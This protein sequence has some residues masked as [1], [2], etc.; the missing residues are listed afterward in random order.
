[1]NR[2][3]EFR[4]ARFRRVLITPPGLLASCAQFPSEIHGRVVSA[5]TNTPRLHGTAQLRRRHGRELIATSSFFLD[6]FRRGASC[7]QAPSK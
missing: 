7:G 2:G 6:F 5:P 3:E 4:F 1:M